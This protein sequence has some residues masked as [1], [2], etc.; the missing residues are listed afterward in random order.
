[1]GRR[2]RIARVALAASLALMG[3]AFSAAPAQAVFHLMK[4]R[5]VYASAANP[6]SEFVELQMYAAGQNFVQGHAVH[7]YSASTNSPTATFDA[8]VPN[9]QTQSTILIASVQAET[10]FGVQADKEITLMPSDFDPTGGAV[11]FENIDCVSWGSFS[12]SPMSPTGTPAPAIPEGSSLERSIAP[13]CPTLLENAD[14]TNDSLTDFGIATPT[15]RNNAT[16][17]TETPCTGGGA[18]GPD[19]QITKKP[20]DKVKKKKV[21]YQFT[22]SVAGA[23]FQ[24]SENGKPFHTCTS[25][26]R[27]KAKKGKNEFEVRAVDAVGNVDQSPAED[28]FKR[29]KR[30]K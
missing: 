10:E 7:F 4:I 19:T 29:K 28:K 11:C 27:F 9:G 13:N 30:K 1:M 16:A 6:G 24:C 8:N 26:H 22:S 21:T 3:L 14:D 5:E 23:T 20:K 17:P 25:P 15:P 12:G 18:G 2:F